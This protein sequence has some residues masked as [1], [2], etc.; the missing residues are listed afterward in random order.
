MATADPRSLPSGQSAIELMEGKPGA[1]VKV[2]GHTLLRAG[3][4]AVGLYAAGDRGEKLYTRAL[5][6]ACA[7]EAFVLVWVAANKAPDAT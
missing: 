1:G 5:G 6:S 3:L 7:I 4:I 2:I